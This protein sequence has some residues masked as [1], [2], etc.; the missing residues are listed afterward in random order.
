[1]RTKERIGVLALMVVS[2]LFLPLRLADA[3]FVANK[4]SCRFIHG[5][6][7][8][9]SSE[10]RSVS[11]Y[12]GG[13]HA[14]KYD[15]DSRISG[16]TAL[17]YEKS[18]VFD[19]AQTTPALDPLPNTQEVPSWAFRKVSVES[20]ENTIR[21]GGQVSIKNEELTWEPF[22]AAIGRSDGSACGVMTVAPS[23]GN[24]AP[25][26]GRN[27]FSDLCLL[28]VERRGHQPTQEVSSALY[29]VVRTETEHWSWR[30]DLQR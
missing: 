21:L 13:H 26:G 5:T 17:N 19:D 6:C 20:T 24:L 9:S 1:M 4:M 11:D 22:Y 28:R 27:N 14:G 8:F 23:S 29:L 18:V 12:M 7:L 16:V 2:C 10:K 15:F 25:R 30:I 3:A